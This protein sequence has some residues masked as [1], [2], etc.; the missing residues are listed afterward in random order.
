MS[1]GLILW[2]LLADVAAMMVMELE[3][4]FPLVR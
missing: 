2:F 1:M 3:S 4:R